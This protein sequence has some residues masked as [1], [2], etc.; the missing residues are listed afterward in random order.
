MDREVDGLRKI[1]NGAG[2]TAYPQGSLRTLFAPQSVA[3]I[4]A[5]EAPGS[6]GRTVL[7]NLTSA[8]FKGAVFAVNPAHEQ[9]LG[10][11][12]YA[13]VADVPE[14]ID[15]A[16]IATPAPTVTGIVR[17]C[18]EAKIQ[19]AIVL[20]AG[21]RECGAEGVEIE[22]RMLAEARRGN[23]RIVGPNC[24]GVMAPRTGLNA[25]FARTIAPSGSVAFLSQSGALCTAVLGWSL[26]AEVGFS[27]FVS[28]GSMLD[29]GW[30][31]LID[32]FGD[33]PDTHS[34]LIYMEA[35]GDAHAFMRAAQH[36]APTKPIIVLKSGRT[37]AG[38]KAAASHTGALTGSDA[39][40]DAAFRRCGVLRVDTIAEL[41]DMAEILACQPRP[42]GPRLT[43]LTNAGGAGVL[44]ADAL[45]AA[46][47]RPAQLRPDT[48]EALNRVLP[49]NW[50]HANPIDI[51]GDATP[52]R[53]AATLEIAAKDPDTD[54]LLVVVTPQ[55]MTDPNRIAESVVPYNGLSGKPILASWMGGEEVAAGQTILRNAGIPTYE[56]PDTAARLFHSLWRYHEILTGLAAPSPVATGAVPIGPETSE[57]VTNETIIHGQEAG[58][59]ERARAEQILENAYR[60][61][62]T[63]LTEPE[64]KQ[65]LIA[66]AIPTVPTRIATS[67]EE[68]VIAANE[69]G[70]PAVLKLYSHTI[71]HKTD[72]GGVKLDLADPY[73]VRAAYDAIEAA[74]CEKAG[75]DCFQGVTVQPMVR[76]EGYEL[77]LGS[78]VDAQFG[79][80]LLFGMGG[81]LV[82]VLE[83]RTLDLPPLT[84]VQARRMIAR[85][86]I[87]KALQGV[88]GRPPVDLAALDRLLVRFSE[89]VAEQR[90]IKEID[91]NPLLAS[92]QGVLALDA[93]IVLHDPPPG[94]HAG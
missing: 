70:Y 82:E 84:P 49:P 18:V 30:G 45:V 86:H 87:F 9:V 16:V 19:T 64:A 17:E 29:I 24:L 62:R 58:G 47:G 69:I 26:R 7:Q 67:A 38:A 43:I 41:F 73:A 61:G 40:L 36:V 71:T 37:E 22:R 66:Y 60:A 92:P 44:A 35:V 3:V 4:G 23:L 56:Y 90:S 55:A 93:R 59:V 12:A 91:I 72:V 54:G 33:D 1:E 65:V 63:L 94:E 25:T 74:V 39:V 11:R 77:I 14:V 89:L 68:A 80:V 21:F 57:A 81:Q 52:E 46:G 48:V 76:T 20:S 10:L 85:T 13:H 2:R 27:A 79:P 51:L 78:S 15:L 32:Y 83:D 28:T 6:V 8:S 31:E 34:I 53:F 42:Q 88:R 50:S 5:S 75:R